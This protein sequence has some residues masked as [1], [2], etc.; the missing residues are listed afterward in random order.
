MR[1]DPVGFDPDGLARAIAAHGPV[2]R[3]VVAEVQGSAPR[4][5]GAS[6]LVWDDGQT[7]TIGGG[8]MEFQATQ[9]ARAMLASGETRRFARAILGPDMGQCC[10]GAVAL[11]YEKF[12][13]VP[14]VG[15]V[16]ARAVEEGATAPDAIAPGPRL[17]NGWFSEPVGPA[18]VPVWIWGAGHVGRALAGVLAP[19]PRLAV[20]LVDTAPERL[21]DPV[22][23]GVGTRVEPEIARAV[24]DAPADARHFILTY[25]HDLDFALCDALLAHGFAGAGLIG[26]ATKWARFRAR[27]V[28]MGHARAAIDRIRCPIGTPA[29]GKD[30]GI[31]AVGVAH[32]LL[33]D[34]AGTEAISPVAG[35]EGAG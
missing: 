20:T 24:R 21:P 22:P 18:P 6:M 32:A 31:L 5:A 15:A 10:G 13:T 8:A 17:D 4:E 7:G 2:V 11:I 25:S 23:A 9:V 1:L 28:Q 33:M 35:R 34:M 3:V 12:E 16:F 26:S 19:L 27:L 30:P 29:L 14:A